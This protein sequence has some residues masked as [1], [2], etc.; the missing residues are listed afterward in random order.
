MRAGE[1]ARAVRRA[2]QT[3]E[4]EL[5]AKAVEIDLPRREINMRISGISE[6]RVGFAARIERDLLVAK[7]HLEIGRLHALR[8]GFD[9]SRGAPGHARILG[10]NP[11]AENGGPI[12]TDL[13]APVSRCREQ[14]AVEIGTAE[15][16]VLLD[17]SLHT[18]PV[19]FGSAGRKTVSNGF[20]VSREATLSLYRPEQRVR[21]AVKRQPG[22]L[23]AFLPVEIVEDDRAV[24]DDDTIELRLFSLACRYRRQRDRARGID[25]CRKTRRVEIGFQ[26]LELAAN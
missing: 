3:A 2:K 18:Q 25:A 22:N 20:A 4:I 26:Y 12:E 6:L 15:Q 19:G 21:T 24:A 8:V 23:G 16:A 17:D 7:S 11:P 5:A 10:S 14:R 1:R 13:L 9:G